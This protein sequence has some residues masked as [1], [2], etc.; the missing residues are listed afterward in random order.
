M[1][2]NDHVS[3]LALHHSDHA[4]LIARAPRASARPAIGLR[5]RASSAYYAAVRRAY[6]H[7]RAARLAAGRAIL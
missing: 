3:L 1:F 2:T 4:E 5:N 7:A 6:V